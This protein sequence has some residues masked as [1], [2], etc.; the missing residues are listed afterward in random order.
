MLI[1]INELVLKTNA[2]PKTKTHW[3][4]PNC[5]SEIIP[6]DATALTANG[7]NCEGIT[8]LYLLT[9]TSSESFFI[10]RDSFLRAKK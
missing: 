4:N 10:D 1:E 6:K 2:P 7:W 9:T 8:D 5:I 3:L